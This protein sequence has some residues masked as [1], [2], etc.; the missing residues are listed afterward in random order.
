[1]PALGVAPDVGADVGADQSGVA[2]DPPAASRPGPGT[3]PLP[4][5]RRRIHGRIRRIT[6]PLGTAAA[7]AA[8]AL[9]PLSRH[10]TAQTPLNG[11]LVALVS[12]SD[13]AVQATVPLQAPPAGV[14]AGAGSV[15]VAEPA[16][17]LRD[18]LLSS[19]VRNY[20]YN[21][22]WGALIDQ[23]WIR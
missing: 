13:G 19:R 3:M 22:V 23:F 9:V 11:N 14:A 17:G 5:P 20:Q 10:G 12:A 21:P 4:R 16:A 18:R 8:L 6:L 1:M 2:T 15:W 7:L